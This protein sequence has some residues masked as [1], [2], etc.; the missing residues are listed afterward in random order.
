M[1]RGLIDR[2]DHARREGFGGGGAGMFNSRSMYVAEE[3]AS[4]GGGLPYAQQDGG[5]KDGPNL[6][7]IW[8]RPPSPR[9][10]W[11][12][13]MHD[14]STPAQENGFDLTTLWPLVRRAA[15]VDQMDFEAALDEMLSLCFCQPQRVFKQAY[16]RKQTKNSWARDDPAF[17]LVQLAFLLVCG[18]ALAAALS[19]HRPAT[20]A[21]LA[22]AAVA[23]WLLGGLVAASATFLLSNAVLRDTRRASHS[24]TQHVEWLYAFDVHCNAFFSYFLVAYVLHY[25][26]LPVALG[27]SIFA[28]IV[29]N[30]LHLAAVAAYCYITHLGFRALPFL[31]NTEV[32]LYP[33]VAT[34]AAFLVALALGVFGVKLNSSRVLVAAVLAPLST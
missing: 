26:V 27:H 31:R 18:V 7:D 32:F 33:V 8:V 34:A 30:A 4:F 10:A 12:R 25:L 15:R 5:A 1:R 9:L 20:Y 22:F 23:H 16:Y 17:A 29:A 24:V 28:L 14:R 21:Y 11:A 13:A 6:S 3:G 2:P 19:A